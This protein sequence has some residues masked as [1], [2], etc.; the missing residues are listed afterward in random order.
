[1][2]TPPPRL[3]AGNAQ[4]VLDAHDT[5]IF[6]MDGV[7]WTG[8]HAIAGSARAIAKLMELGKTVFFMTNNSTKHRSEYIP[9]LEKLGFTGISVEQI[10]SS[11]YATA[12]YLKDQ[13]FEG[14]VFAAAGDGLCKELTE[15]G[16]ENVGGFDHAK[17]NANRELQE[18]IDIVVDPEIRAVVTGW[19]LYMNYFQISYASLVLNSDP[20]VLFLATNDDR[21]TPQ[22]KQK[23]MLPGGGFVMAAVEWATSRK[24]TVVGKPTQF[25]LDV[26]FNKHPGLNRERAMMIGDRLDTDI[27][28]GNG[29]GLSTLLVLSGTTTEEDAFA[30]RGEAGPSFVSDAIRDLTDHLPA[31]AGL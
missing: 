25:M 2:S 29:G 7:L 8:D 18:C 14:K 22:G 16:I 26:I 9:K 20:S 4:A 5:F 10:Y 31:P 6:D 21:L 13:G 1:M 15:A 3:D 27:A 19:N 30:G 24:A 12:L 23:T 17:A 11:G 28:F